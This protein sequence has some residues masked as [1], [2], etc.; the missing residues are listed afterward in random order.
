MKKIK[1]IFVAVV[2][3]FVATNNLTA[4]NIWMEGARY[5]YLDAAGNRIGSRNAGIY[6]NNGGI[7]DLFS[8]SRYNGEIYTSPYSDVN[9]VVM[10]PWSSKNIYPI[11]VS[12]ALNEGVKVNWEIVDEKSND[13]LA[14]R[15]I[16]ANTGSKIKFT[17]EVPE[18]SYPV[19]NT[20]YAYTYPDI[21]N[22]DYAFKVFTNPYFLPIA[23]GTVD[24]MEY[25]KK[26]LESYESTGNFI[27][28]KNNPNI[29]YYYSWMQN[30]PMS[31]NVTCM[32]VNND[33]LRKA[34]LYVS[35]SLYRQYQGY[36]INS[37]TNGEP[38]LISFLGN[39]MGNDFVS[40][41][42]TNV[43]I[44]YLGK[45]NAII[46][47]AYWYDYLSIIAN[48]NLLLRLIDRFSDTDQSVRDYVTAEM[49]T[50]RA[51]AY[52]R[53][54]QVFGPRWNESENGTIPVAPLETEFATEFSAPASM[55][56]IANQCYDDLDQAINLFK[57]ANL[58]RRNMV[59]PDI[60][61]AKGVKMRVAT[62]REDWV[63]ASKMAR[64]ILDAVPATTNEQLTDGMFKAA[65]SWIW[66]ASNIY[67]VDYNMLYFWA[68]QCQNSC[69]GVYPAL[70]QIGT[71]AIDRDLF[72]AM[73]EKDIRR[74]MFVMPES[75]S[76]PTFSET[77][78][79]Y[80][81]KYITNREGNI[82]YGFVGLDG[83]SSYRKKLD[84]Y[85]AQNAPADCSPAFAT[86]EY[87]ATTIPIQFGAQT[88]FY[89]PS[90]GI[91]EAMD[92]LFMR[93][94]EAKLTLA[95]A[96]YNLGEFASA[97]HNLNELNMQRI[98][99]YALQTPNGEDLLDAIKLARR[100]ELWGEGFDWFDMKRW[101]V[102]RSR[103]LWIENDVKSGNWPVNTNLEADVKAANGWR[104]AIPKS[105][106]KANPF[107]N[108]D[109]YKYTS[110]AG[111]EDVP[112][113]EAQIPEQ[114]SPANSKT[115]LTNSSP[116]KTLNSKI[117]LL[118]H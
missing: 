103:R 76:I 55:M 56:E 33:L 98:E 117:E 18:G 90:S 27:K 112:A 100:V 13:V 24:N 40:N 72:L 19:F 43:G 107:I 48:A 14:T 47:H 17:I 32:R 39:G 78:F 88:K 6:T 94:E 23:E 53:L 69:N 71:N 87:D 106:V 22:F 51:H 99:G 97:A 89:T 38:F 74:K 11:S 5:D 68:F 63:E 9:S 84:Q 67:P 3:L 75:L 52:H 64:E 29:W 114:Q 59:E 49:L 2:S 7:N 20:E 66:G 118:N 116:I 8:F 95:E 36:S 58:Q 105:A 65:P 108:L 4:D 79:W 93:S 81:P 96:C 80:N 15:P 70:W 85:F 113:A 62:L 104:F 10:V 44:E 12:S 41:L 28:D 61:V 92:V 73:D 26:V 54:M 102:P 34:A 50:L 21:D 45:G 60:N 91:Y 37:S 110:V 31:F 109:A 42:Y 86:S 57:S 101:S 77:S 35:S 25:R 115:K 83:N 111:Y 46:S 82:D 30:E 1:T 16:E